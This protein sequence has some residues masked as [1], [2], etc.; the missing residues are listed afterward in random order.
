MSN[1]NYSILSSV[2]FKEKPE[3]LEQSIVSM[4]EQ[5]K[6]T[7]DYVIVRDGPLTDELDAV[8]KKYRESNSNIKIIS[9]EKNSGLGAALNVGLKHCKNE[10]VARMDTD[11]IADKQRCEMQLEEFEKNSELDIVGTFMYEFSDNPNRIESIKT[12]PVTQE[13][14]YKFGKRRNPFNHPTVMYKKSTVMN[15]GGYPETHRGEDID[16]FT[17]MI[18]NKCKTKNIDKPLLK[19]RSSADMFKRRTSWIDTKAYISVMI[20]SYKMGYAGLKDLLYVFLI[21]G[22]A[23]ICP[24]FLGRRIHKKLFRKSRIR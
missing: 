23:M 6:P 4:L 17:R 10:L 14:I 3:F 16:L 13:E 5:T 15:Y 24:T 8:L 2:Y 7:D 22:G 9:L 18:F 11:D 20:R 1:L 21:Q 19:Y 12:V